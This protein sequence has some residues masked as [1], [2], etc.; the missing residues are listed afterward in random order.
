MLEDYCRKLILTNTVLDCENRIAVAQILNLTEPQR[1]L[2]NLTAA[3]S[4]VGQSGK[5]YE[6]QKKKSGFKKPFVSKSGMVEGK[7]L[8][9]LAKSQMRDNMRNM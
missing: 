3:L 4:F 2:Q 1:Q 7:L 9:S 8:Q 6:S 5:I